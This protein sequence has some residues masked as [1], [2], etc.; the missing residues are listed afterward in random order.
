MALIHLPCIFLV[1]PAFNILPFLMFFHLFSVYNIFWKY[2][3]VYSAFSGL[4]MFFH[5]SSVFRATQLSMIL[6]NIFARLI[7]LF[8]FDNS[9][10]ILLTLFFFS[11]FIHINRFIRVINLNSSLNKIF[12]RA[13]FS[14]LQIVRMPERGLRVLNAKNN[15][16]SACFAL[17]RVY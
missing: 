12:P 3:H 17:F 2:F 8:R 5:V 6:E 10:S 11:F 16:A 9:N 4:F 14:H 15:N 1:F 7:N 13:C